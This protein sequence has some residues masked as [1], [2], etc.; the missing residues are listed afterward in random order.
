MA[1]GCLFAA[2]TGLV[3]VAFVFVLIL[4]HLAFSMILF[5]CLLALAILWIIKPR[6]NA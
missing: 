3:F 6:M 1:S 2:L 4:T 5:F